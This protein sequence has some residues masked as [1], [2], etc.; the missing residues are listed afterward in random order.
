MYLKVVSDGSAVL[1][2]NS[3]TTA[4]AYSYE[5][6]GNPMGQAG[7]TVNLAKP[8]P[9]RGGQGRHGG[10]ASPRLATFRYAGALGYYTDKTTVL[11]HVGARYYSPQ[12]GRFWTQ[13]P[14]RAEL[15]RYAYVRSN[16]C[17]S[18]DPDGHLPTFHNCNGPHATQIKDAAR[19][20]LAQ[21]PRMLR[22]LTGPIQHNCVW[23]FLL[24]GGTVV[25]SSTCSN[26]VCG[27]A[28][29]IPGHPSPGGKGT[30]YIC[31]A[32]SGPG[33]GTDLTL[34]HEIM[35]VCGS[36]DLGP[37]QPNPAENKA[38]CCLGLPRGPVNGPPGAWK[39]P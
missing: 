1:T 14:A 8:C 29:G 4:D 31:D 38:R 18:V 24:S 23:D 10:A 22:C 28:F 35:H 25:C 30:V 17:T 33:C 5:A 20:L 9:P 27:C 36:A 7:T 37:G 34:L 13:D 21:A 2:I 3:Q 6:F 39:C 11:Y 12:V 19:R 15:N 16:P 26:N 32:A